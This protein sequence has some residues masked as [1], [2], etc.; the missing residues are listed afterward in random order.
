MAGRKKG[1]AERAEGG[2]NGGNALRW[3]RVLSDVAKENVTGLYAGTGD[4]ISWV[5]LSPALFSFTRYLSTLKLMMAGAESPPNSMDEHPVAGSKRQLLPRL[6][7]LYSVQ[8]YA[9]DAPHDLQS[10]RSGRQTEH[11]ALPPER[12]WGMGAEMIWDASA[13]RGRVN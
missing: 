9:A 10:P 12:P 1:I 13:G 3:Q 6:L 2:K 11:W 8:G 7:H 4:N 5:I